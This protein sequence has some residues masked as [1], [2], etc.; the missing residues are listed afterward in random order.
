MSIRN[1][2]KKMIMWMQVAP[3]R[4]NFGNLL[5]SVH[6]EVESMLRPPCS[7]G[8]GASDNSVLALTGST[9]L[10]ARGLSSSPCMRDVCDAIIVQALQ[11]GEDTAGSP[12]PPKSGIGYSET[13]DPQRSASGVLQQQSSHFVSTWP[14]N[15]RSPRQQQ[16]DES[17]AAVHFANNAGS[18]QSH[19]ADSKSDS[20][21]FSESRM[22]KQIGVS[23][24]SSESQ[25]SELIGDCKDKQLG[26]R[27]S[28]RELCGDQHESHLTDFPSCSS[29]S[30][31]YC[32]VSAAEKVL[33]HVIDAAAGDENGSKSSD[34]GM[35]KTEAGVSSHEADD[36]DMD[37][38]PLCIDLNRD[39]SPDNDDSTVA[40]L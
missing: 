26:S 10:M 31:L 13:C 12:R 29:E 18:Q 27:I 30:K 5:S 16:F 15:S 21:Q 38:Q 7:D 35:K 1:C 23:S 33:T 39:T 24:R 3:P 40:H 34:G 36:I 9:G 37:D 8:S 2:S 6:R 19:F 25:M 11:Q 28:N 4:V 22:S 14:P 17:K 32:P 20:S